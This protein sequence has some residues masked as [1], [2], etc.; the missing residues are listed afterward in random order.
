M[1]GLLVPSLLKDSVREAPRP[2][3]FSSSSR[4]E[5]CR[6]G[7]IFPLPPFWE[8]PRHR[9]LSGSTSS[10]TTYRVRGP[11]RYGE[12]PADTGGD[13]VFPV[14]LSR[15]F[16]GLCDSK[17]NV[18]LGTNLTGRQGGIYPGSAQLCSYG[19]RVS[20]RLELPAVDLRPQ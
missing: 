5:D 7:M 3:D 2:E 18:P 1:C 20:S 12:T 6:T 14:F 10:A 13:D 8:T 4:A 16:P 17:G 15:S 9:S 11:T 19:L